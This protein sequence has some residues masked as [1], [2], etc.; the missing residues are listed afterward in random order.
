ME[1]VETPRTAGE[2]GEQVSEV[3]DEGQLRYSNLRSL[4]LG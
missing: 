2:K 4:V 1:V 3:D